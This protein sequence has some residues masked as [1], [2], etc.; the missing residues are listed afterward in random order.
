MNPGTIKNPIRICVHLRLSAV[1]MYEHESVVKIAAFFPMADGQIFC[2]AAHEFFSATL[3]CPQSH[4]LCLA[5]I[6]RV[7]IASKMK[8]AD[9]FISKT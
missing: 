2:M 4:T 1:K 6:F 9:S 7:A 5:P 8:R 3:F